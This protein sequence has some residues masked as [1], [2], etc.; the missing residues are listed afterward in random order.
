MVE[1]GLDAGCHVLSE[2]PLAASMEEAAT[3][4]E[5]AKSRQNS[6]R[7]AKPAV[8]CRYPRLRRALEDGVIGD[9]TAIHCDFFLGP[10]F[11]GFREEMKNVLLLD[12][13]IHTFDAARFVANE[14]PLSVFALRRTRPAPGMPTGRA[15]T[16]FSSSPMMSSSPIAVHGAPRASG[17][18]GKRAGG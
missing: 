13:A 18:A 7:G 11:G 6:C 14:K 10:H 8:Y 4:V 5:L 1:A 17:P 12:M 15:P 9:L 3:L 2:K 16:P